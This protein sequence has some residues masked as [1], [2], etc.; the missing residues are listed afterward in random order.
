VKIVRQKAVIVCKSRGGIEQLG[1][2]LSNRFARHGQRRNDV[3]CGAAA[4]DEYAQI[5]QVSAF[6]DGFSPSG[7]GSS[8]S[9]SFSY[10]HKKTISPTSPTASVPKKEFHGRLEKTISHKES[11][12]YIRLAAIPQPFA[13]FF[14]FQTVHQATPK[15]M[16]KTGK[17]AEMIWICN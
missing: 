6:Q 1:I 4:S 12:T 7:S 17:N 15:M 2:V 8:V 5:W 9:A 13:E 10:G 14:C 16:A 3:A 11:K